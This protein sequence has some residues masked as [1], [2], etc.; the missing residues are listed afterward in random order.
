[1][2]AWALACRRRASAA[3]R[4]C[5]PQAW[6]TASVA[7]C[8]RR[9]PGRPPERSREPPP[10][11]PTA[12][13]S[14]APSPPTAR[15]AVWQPPRRW[16]P[17]SA[18]APPSGRSA[19]KLELRELAPVPSRPVHR[20]PPSGE[21]A[22]GS[23]A[24]GDTVLAYHPTTDKSEPEPVQHV[25]LN[26]DTDL[27]DVRVVPAGATA[28]AVAASTATAT[29]TETHPG[30]GL[31]AG[32]DANSAAH[33]VTS[34]PSTSSSSSTATAGETLHTTANHPWLT[35]DRGWVPA[36]AFQPG[37]PL[38]TLTGGSSGTVAWVHGVP[39]QADRY[40]LTVAHDHTYAVG[41]SRAVVH[42]EGCDDPTGAAK[43][44]AQRRAAQ[45]LAPADTAEGKANV[46]ARLDTNGKSYYGQNGRSQ[47][48][49]I[50]VNN[51]SI[52][53]AEANA[54]QSA[55]ND[56]VNGG[57]AVLYVDQPLCSACRGGMELFGYQ[58]GLSSLR[59]YDPT[60]LFMSLEWE[61]VFSIQA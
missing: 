41:A 23:L 59:I 18:S 25:W 8:P 19:T 17:A 22:I 45:G 57:D 60:G 21:R 52:Y 39:G 33:L 38:V 9:C 31:L 27:V 50:R 40:N 13:A 7:C 15:G 24:I 26:H 37:E 32:D 51:I 28:T 5:S 14:P 43:D 6:P 55:F 2:L 49:T 54:F 10:G 29:V 30:H 20:W 47:P 46:L 48:I 16:A 61:T 56:G 53:H 1:M 36:G 34:Q 3:S 42:N 11:E 44:L 58:L 12:T 35:V 4:A